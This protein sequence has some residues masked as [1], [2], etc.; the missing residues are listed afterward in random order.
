MPVELQP[1][2]CAEA[3]RRQR[4][5]PGAR[6]GVSQPSQEVAPD[7]PEIQ[8]REGGREPHPQQQ[9]PGQPGPGRPRPTT[10]PA[11]S[12]P[13]PGPG[14]SRAGAARVA[15]GSPAP[16]PQAGPTPT[17]LSI[18]ARPRRC[19]ARGQTARLHASRAG[20]SART[21]GSRNTR[22]RRGT[23]AIRAGPSEPQPAR[24]TRDDPQEAE[25]GGV[26][27][28]ERRRPAPAER[29]ADRPENVIL[30]GELERRHV[31][32]RQP[33][34]LVP[35]HRERGEMV[36]VDPPGPGQ[37]LRHPAGEQ[38]HAS[39]PDRDRQGHPQRPSL[40]TA[41][42][43]R[44]VGNHRLRPRHVGGP[45]GGGGACPP[46]T[47]FSTMNLGRRRVSSRLRHMYSPR[48]PVIR[49]CVPEITRKATI[50]D[51]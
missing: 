14:P 7:S 4:A 51:A 44:S 38:G 22:R 18:P 32:I 23:P 16:R 28:V 45:A 11:A 6:P 20:P 17:A 42:A 31:A 46:S 34:P 13:R 35:R 25:R 36:V 37:I 10:L 49:S 47:T 15:A 24:P 9:S 48:M 27:R 2:P 39:R 40:E 26:D 1:E 29:L 43:G 33:L 21:P 19:P 12:P 41:P 8:R 3:R 5:I 50:K 30:A